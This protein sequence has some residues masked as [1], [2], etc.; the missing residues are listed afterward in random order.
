MKLAVV[1]N[2][3]IS[4]YVQRSLAEQGQTIAAMILRPQRIASMK[5]SQTIGIPLAASISELPGGVTH[6]IDCSGHRGLA[7]HGPAALRAGYDV[8]TVSIGAL[9]DPDVMAELEAAAVEGNSHLHLASGA[10]GS[11]D[12]LQAARCGRLDSVRYQGRKPPAGWIGSPADQRLDL[13]RPMDGPQTH[14]SGTAREAALLYPKNANVAAA[15]ALAGIGFDSTQVELIAD[16]DV[17]ANI[18]EI[19]ASGEF[20]TFSFTIAGKGLPDN[21]RT[22]ALAAMSIVSAI[23]KVQHPVQI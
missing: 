3:A 2:G 4:S 7:E 12:T 14:F 16:P 8:I 21:P 19:H 17:S 20:G 23:A 9:A 18:H 1:G 11:L 13:T 15:V 5:V 6:V 22:S 10:I